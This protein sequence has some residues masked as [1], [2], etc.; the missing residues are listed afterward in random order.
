MLEEIQ[1]LSEANKKR[2]LVFGTVI[3]MLIVLGVWVAY[4]NGIIASASQPLTAQSTSTDATDAA[5]APVPIAIQ[6][7]TTP[8]TNGPGLWQNI[9]DGMASIANIFKRPSQYDIQPQSN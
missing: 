1:A 3:I 5:A 2:V 6:P 4:F 8:A 9:E 7:A